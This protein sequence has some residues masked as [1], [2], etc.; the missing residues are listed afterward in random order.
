MD[1]AAFTLEEVERT[2]VRCPDPEAAERMY[3]GAHSIF[4]T[5][6]DA[7]DELPGDQCIVFH[8]MCWLRTSWF[9]TCS[10]GASCMRSH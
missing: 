8:V 6:C 2:P 7:A 10:D 1:N 5:I 3:Q 9:L 4:R